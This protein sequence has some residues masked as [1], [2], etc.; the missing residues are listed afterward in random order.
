MKASIVLNNYIDCQV[1]QDYVICV[2]GGYNYCLG[3]CDCIIGDLDSIGNIPVEVKIIKF[4]SRKNQTDGELAIRQA[5]S[6]GYNDL[7]IYGGIGGRIDHTIGNLGLLPLAYSLN[8]KAILLSSTLEVFFVKDSL[9]F[10]TKLDDIVSIFS[11][12]GN[13]VVSSVSGLSY[14]LDN[15]TLEELSTRGVSNYA[16]KTQVSIV[17]SSGSVFV[18]HYLA[19]QE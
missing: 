6:C 14:P 4:D 18:F 13:A 2:D 12:D 7:T 16:V 8:A 9:T 17:I 10:E 15:L 19:K 11:F 1:K 3:K 5:I